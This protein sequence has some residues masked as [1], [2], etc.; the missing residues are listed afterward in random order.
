MGQIPDSVCSLG[1]T[2]A[3]K[4]RLFVWPSLQLLETLVSANVVA[5]HEHNLLKWCAEEWCLN[6]QAHKHTVLN[7][8]SK[9]P[10]NEEEE[11]EEKDSKSTSHSDSNMNLSDLVTEINNTILHTMEPC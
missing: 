6:R 11:E 5:L 7:K 2:D 8:K 4:E 9:A 10:D 1:R 3:C